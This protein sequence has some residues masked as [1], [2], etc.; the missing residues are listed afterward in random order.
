[1]Q[2][3]ISKVFSQKVVLLHTNK[4][5]FDILAVVTIACLATE[6]RQNQSCLF[7]YFPEVSGQGL[8]SITYIWRNYT[9]LF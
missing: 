6:R 3:V 2:D 9:V 8:P 4:G 5:G 1:M 7:A